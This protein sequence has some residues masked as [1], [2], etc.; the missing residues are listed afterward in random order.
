MAGGDGNYI[1]MCVSWAE[2][3]LQ[4]EQPRTQ[5]QCPNGRVRIN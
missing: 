3:E 2:F 5:T 1:T 4:T